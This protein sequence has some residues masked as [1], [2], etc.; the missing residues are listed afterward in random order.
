MPKPSPAGPTPPLRV[1]F[2][3]PLLNHPRPH[4]RIEAFRAWGA[5]VRVM[6]FERAWDFVDRGGDVDVLGVVEDGRFARRLGRYARSVPTIRAAARGVDVIYTFGTDLLGLA[7]L[8]TRKLRSRPRLCMEMGDVRPILQRA[9][10]RG[11][12][13]RAIDRRSIAPVDLLVVT[14]P[15]FVEHFYERVQGIDDLRWRLVE[16][17]VPE[18]APPQPDPPTGAWDGV[19]RIAYPGLLNCL[20]TWETLSLLAERGGDR[21]Q[22]DMHGIPSGPLTNLAERCA[23]H[24]NIRLHPPYNMP[25]ELGRVF[26][27]CD[28]GWMAHVYESPDAPYR[29]TSRFYQAGYWRRP[30]IGQ[31][32]TLDGRIIDE[33]GFG[34]MIDLRDPAGSVERL[35][36]ITPDEVDGWRANVAAAPVEMFRRTHQLREVFDTLSGLGPAP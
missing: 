23:A 34:P 30:M 7:W 28:F 33:Q 21:V 14:S 16:N 2:L 1:L 29:R 19:L 12:V 35:L 4:Q 3:L 10:W 27:P 11:G 6:G 9:D 32:D 36:A 8:A 20:P 5:D 31:P 15:A 25:E 22:I 18:D 17:K 24:P 26:G 13:A